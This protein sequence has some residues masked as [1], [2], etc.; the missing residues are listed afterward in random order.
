MDAHMY[1]RQALSL[2]EVKSALNARKLQEKQGNLD[3]KTSKG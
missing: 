2:D 1:G 3:Y